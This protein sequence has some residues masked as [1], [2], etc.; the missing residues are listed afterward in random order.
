MA[1]IGA[2]R[3]C[4]CAVNAEAAYTYM[5][6]DEEAAGAGWLLYLVRPVGTLGFIVEGNIVIVELRF[7]RGRGEARLLI[8]YWARRG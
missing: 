5:P 1:R 4:K 8:R 3:C 2:R 7:F 6:L